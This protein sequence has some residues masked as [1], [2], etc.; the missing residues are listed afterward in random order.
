MLSKQHQFVQTAVMLPRSMEPIRA[1]ATWQ[2][3]QYPTEDV[4]KMLYTKKLC[5]QKLETILWRAK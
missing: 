5:R 4:N 1:P 3:G 2:C